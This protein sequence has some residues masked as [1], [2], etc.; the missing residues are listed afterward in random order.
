MLI[1]KKTHTSIEFYNFGKAFLASLLTFS[2][3]NLKIFIR[4]ISINH[5]HKN[6]VLLL[7]DWM[8]TIFLKIVFKLI[9]G[10]YEI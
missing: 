1:K 4:N 7:K 3:I 6:L 9:D 2:T 8:K 5:L 10:V